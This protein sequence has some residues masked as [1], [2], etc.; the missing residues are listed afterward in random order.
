MADV[1]IATN[2]PGDVTIEKILIKLA[3][4]NKKLSPKEMAAFL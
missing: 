2:F 3:N 1:K 4:R